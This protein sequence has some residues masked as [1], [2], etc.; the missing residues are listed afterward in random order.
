MARERNL[1]LTLDKESNF[2]IYGNYE[3]EKGDYLFTLQNVIG[4]KL[5]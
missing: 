4:K 5:S 3:I 2:Y 1:R